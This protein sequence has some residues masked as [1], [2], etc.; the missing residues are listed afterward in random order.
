MIFN[1]FQ[2]VTN[3]EKIVGSHNTLNIYV[4]KIAGALILFFIK[5]YRF[6][7]T[8][9]KSSIIKWVL[10]DFYSTFK[11]KVHWNKKWNGLQRASGA[12]EF[13]PL[14]KSTPSQSWTWKFFLVLVE[15]LYNN[16][17]KEFNCPFVVLA[18]FQKVLHYC[19]CRIL[20]SCI[21]PNCFP[22]YWVDN[23]G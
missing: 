9:E 7:E 5:S 1:D 22:L 4:I 8:P 16:L 14:K 20:S 13:I 21:Y 15:T 17:V 3:N 11:N 18:I 23:V 6:I 2:W 12:A 19:S 10:R